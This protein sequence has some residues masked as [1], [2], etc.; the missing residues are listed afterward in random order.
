MDSEQRGKLTREFRERALGYVAAG[1][2]LV[3]GLA[4]NEAIR[5]LIEFA[6]PLERDSLLAKFVY[7]VLMTGVVVL[8]TLAIAR[9]FKKESESR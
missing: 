3:A 5:G 6:F 1:F 2:G 4:W 7:A 9:L 8:V